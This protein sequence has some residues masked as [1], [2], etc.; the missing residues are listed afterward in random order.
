MGN[1]KLQ[2]EDQIAE[3]GGG[4]ETKETTLDIWRVWIRGNL[5]PIALA[6]AVFIRQKFAAFL[7]LHATTGSLKSRRES[8][9]RP[10]REV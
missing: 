5:H 9:S 10:R 3:T 2:V 7:A 8:W 6:T 4:K 1:C